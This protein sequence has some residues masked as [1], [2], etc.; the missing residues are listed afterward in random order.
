MPDEPRIAEKSLQEN[1]QEA[2]A[3]RKG[4]FPQYLMIRYMMLEYFLLESFLLEYLS[5]TYIRSLKVSPQV[6][7]EAILLKKLLPRPDLTSFLLYASI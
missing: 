7:G 5:N 6:R 3:E 1:N 4:G 2:D